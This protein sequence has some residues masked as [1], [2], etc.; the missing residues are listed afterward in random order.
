MPGVGCALS[1]AGPRADAK[2]PPG[3]ITASKWAYRLEFLIP[4]VSIWTARRPATARAQPAL[5]FQP[6]P[7]SPPN[8]RC[9]ERGAIDAGRLQA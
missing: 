1:V 7:T 6:H 8:G 9:E 4:Q 2:E 3:R 5:S